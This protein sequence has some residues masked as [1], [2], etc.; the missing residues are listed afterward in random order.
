MVS[1]TLSN[2]GSAAA[3]SGRDGRYGANFVCAVANPINKIPTFGI[4]GGNFT[5]S[6]FITS[7]RPYPKGEAL[8]AMITSYR[9]YRL[10]ASPALGFRLVSQQGHTRL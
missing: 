5:V 1:Q 9:P 7:Y 8:A 3:A 4:R 2:F 6:N 10:L